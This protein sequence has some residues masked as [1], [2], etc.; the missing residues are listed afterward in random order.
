MTDDL[1][2]N[3]EEARTIL[4]DT[5]ERA[6]KDDSGSLDKNEFVSYMILRDCKK[7]MEKEME[8]IKKI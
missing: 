6:D 4:S 7:L 8:N 5:F 1:K 3:T 2:P